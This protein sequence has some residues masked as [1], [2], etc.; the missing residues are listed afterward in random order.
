V[1]FC[2]CFAGSLR[3]L[4]HFKNEVESVKNDV[5]CG[6]SFDDQSVAPQTGD[7]VVCFEYRQMKP[8]LDWNLEF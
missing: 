2:G 4:K 5:E 3:S 7:V 1:Y 6:L 8:E